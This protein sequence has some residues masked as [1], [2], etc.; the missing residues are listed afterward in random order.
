MYNLE[1]SLVLQRGL[2]LLPGEG[3]MHTLHTHDLGEETK[4]VFRVSLDPFSKVFTKFWNTKDEG[5]SLT[6]TCYLR[7]YLGVLQLGL[8]QPESLN[9]LKN[10]PQFSKCK[11]LEYNQIYE[12]FP[13][14][15]LE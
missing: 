13:I 4:E 3:Y 14:I 9:C 10:P 2:M 1:A 8:S 12:V 5:S 7:D 11:Y 15:R 6:P